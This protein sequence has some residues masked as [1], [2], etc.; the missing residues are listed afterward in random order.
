MSSGSKE[1][2]ER[3]YKKQ[4]IV[5]N[6]TGEKWG[7]VKRVNQT[8]PF[9]SARRF[10]PRSQITEV[11]EAASHTMWQAG[12]TNSLRNAVDFFQSSSQRLNLHNFTKSVSWIG[13]YMYSDCCDWWI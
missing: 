2:H 7:A 3:E 13:Y 9:F 4:K 10:S 1:N 5:Q 8:F 6:N 11:P 12:V